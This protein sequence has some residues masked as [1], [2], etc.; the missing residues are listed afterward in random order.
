MALIRLGQSITD[1]RGP[2]GGIYFTRDKSGLHCT[3]KPRRVHQ[4]SS[5]QNR[6]RNA[7]TRARS[8]SKINRVVSYN[9]YRAL[10]GL[11]MQ[12]PPPDYNPP[13]L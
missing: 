2:V 5:A 3:S 11:P 4:R 12:L 8:Y 7:F 10:T 9:V 1:I 6:Q 13:G